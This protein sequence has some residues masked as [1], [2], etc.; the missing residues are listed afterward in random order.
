M[1]KEKEWGEEIG[2]TQ[3][4]A[5]PGTGSVLDFISIVICS[6]DK[7]LQARHREAGNSVPVG[8]FITSDLLPEVTIARRTP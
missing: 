5:H 2:D 8:L 1:P 6:T 7:P 4:Q 3:H